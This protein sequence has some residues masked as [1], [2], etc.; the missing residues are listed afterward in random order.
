MPRQGEAADLAGAGIQDM[1]QHALAL[2][3]A[4]R[5]AVAELFAVDAEKLVAD[6]VAFR[7]FELLVELFA[8]L[9]QRRNRRSRQRL[10]LPVAALA[11]GRRELL[12]HQKH[13]A[14]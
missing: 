1:E 3:D 6:F 13:F 11:E 5:L 4:D 7:T 10:L 2:F 12:L 14:I 9:R 8:D